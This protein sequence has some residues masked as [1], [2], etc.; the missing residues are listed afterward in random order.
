MEQAYKHNFV[1]L[2][3][4][5]ENSLGD[6]MCKISK[7]I[8]KAKEDGMPAIAL[9]DHGNMFGIKEFIDKVTKENL[10]RAEGEPEFKPII[11]M[12]AYCARR[13]LNDKD[14]LLVEID[15]VTDI[16]RLID[17][18]GYRL[19]ILAKN[20]DG[21]HSLCK[22]ASLSYTDGF[23]RGVPR[24]D[25]DILTIY[26]EGLIVLS[27]G[28]EGELAQL[29]L[30][31]D[32]DGAEKAAEWYKELFGEDYYIE[33]MRHKTDKPDANLTIYQL[34][35]KVEPELIRIA[36]KLKIKL[37]ATNDVHFL[38]EEHG[39]A[40]DHYVCLANNEE[41]DSPIRKRYTKQ[42]WLKS[43]AEMYDAF[44]DLPEALETTME[45]ADKVEIYP[46]RQVQ[47][48]P[49]VP[50]P[51]TF[52]TE[53]EY[54]GHI[55]WEGAAKRYG[56]NLTDEQRERITH[57]LDFIKK[58]GFAGYFLLVWDIVR[59]ARE[60]LDVAVGPGRSSAAG[61][62][63][64]YCLRI[65]DVDPLRYGLLFERV[66]SAPHIKLP[67]FDI[68]FEADGREK[69][70]EWFTKKYGE[71]R[72]AHIITF[73]HMATKNS[74]AEMQR[75]EKMPIDAIIAHKRLIPERGF[76]D[77][78]KNEK[79]CSP[80]VNLPNCYKF[81][82]EFRSIMES[83]DDKMKHIL[84]MAAEVENTKRYPGIHACGIVVSPQ[85]ISDTVPL[86]V[87]KDTD[88]KRVVVTQYD[89]HDVEDVG[90]VKLDF[91][92]LIT[93]T[94][95]KKCVARIKHTYG[96]D[97]D[98]NNI[99]LDDMSTYKLFAE[100]NT[101]G[102]FQFESAGMQIHLRKLQTR[103][104]T[105]L[106]A[107]NAQYRPGTMHNIAKLIKRKHGNE[108][109]S[110]LLP[111]LEPFLKET[112]GITV[113]QEQ[114]MQISQK[115]AGFSPIESN[116]LRRAIGM[117]QK[118]ALNFIEH[119]FYEGGQKNGYSKE[120][121]SQIWNEWI[122]EDNLAFNKSHAVCYTWLAY[123]TAYLKAHYPA[124]YMATLISL[125]FKDTNRIKE[126]LT[127][128]RNNGLSVN[129]QTQNFRIGYKDGVE[130]MVGYKEISID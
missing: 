88:R 7:L 75:L 32:L 128:C 9:T 122:T 111:E 52:K 77:N 86:C 76:P 83:D 64:A 19:T 82:P 33:L 66:F 42:E 53:D 55:V 25:R 16:N 34:Q 120:I 60:E 27:G 11:G 24:I 13:T 58:N 81:I 85:D 74:L 54:L 68:D 98:I 130:H 65:T 96:T 6:G 14:S 63:V 90:L 36:R 129:I 102:V 79:G 125:A 30:K 45:I 97:I 46:I 101:V 2:N 72:V 116:L 28:I 89:G 35:M 21:Y 50:I 94:T 20:I 44:S 118:D 38:R 62:I 103:S 10:S 67:D 56:D 69:V 113:Y 49:T 1:H 4:H 22:L 105:D 43:P 117:R 37:V 5:T 23:F 41:L 12:D 31:G 80:I 99:P 119:Q 57:E 15:P 51:D 3:V 61:S 84:A 107:L 71:E 123:Q 40:H 59:A 73:A 91:L 124:E 29:I 109:I 47:K 104:F 100:G 70:I 93:L 87:I 112:Y 126:L 78:I 106:V 121:L 95:I 114:I 8:A 110:Y 127:D 17:A 18:G 39:D 48:L 92:G 115:L 108:E 26:K